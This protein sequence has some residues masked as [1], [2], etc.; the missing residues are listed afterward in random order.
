MTAIKEIIN[1]PAIVE[2]YTIKEGN[3][4]LGTIELTQSGD[5]LCFINYAP[6]KGFYSRLKFSS[7]NDALKYLFYIHTLDYQITP[8]RLKGVKYPKS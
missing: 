4:I 8:V 1:S 5:Y 2:K 6:K 7:Y 3:R